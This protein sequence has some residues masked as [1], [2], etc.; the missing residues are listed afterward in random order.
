MNKQ[1]TMMALTRPAQ[2]GQVGPLH[3]HCQGLQ[4]FICQV[5]RVP[6]YLSTSVSRDLPPKYEEVE[7]L[8]PPYDESTMPQNSTSQQQNSCHAIQEHSVI[9]SSAK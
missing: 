9:S 8:P 6:D 4:V 5:E 1:F 2:M 7:D 3:S